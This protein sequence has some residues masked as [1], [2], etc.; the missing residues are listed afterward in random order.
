LFLASLRIPALLP[1]EL[2]W[3]QSGPINVIAVT[4]IPFNGN[5]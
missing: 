1:G 2:V 4:T 5:L 3:H